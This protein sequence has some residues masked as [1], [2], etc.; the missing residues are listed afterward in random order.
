[1]SFLSQMSGLTGYAL[2]EPRLFSLTWVP[3]RKT[4]LRGC[5]GHNDDPVILSQFRGI[6]VFFAPVCDLLRVV[7]WYT[8]EAYIKLTRPQVVIAPCCHGITVFLAT[9]GG[10]WNDSHRPL[11]LQSGNGGLLRFFDK[12]LH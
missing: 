10:H 6:L 4:Q 11:F 5:D 7:S 3:S 12:G 9:K 2:R 8:V 1:M